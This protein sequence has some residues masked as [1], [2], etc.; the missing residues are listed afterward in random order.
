VAIKEGILVGISA[1]AAIK[2]AIIVGSRPENKDKNI[3]LIVAS[4]GESLYIMYI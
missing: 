4:F 2:A 1:G 3:V